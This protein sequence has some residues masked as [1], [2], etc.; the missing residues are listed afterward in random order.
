MNINN[1]AIY[2]NKTVVGLTRG[3][4]Y[5]YKA[6]NLSSFTN[7]EQASSRKYRLKKYLNWLNNTCKQKHMMM[8][9][10]TET[11]F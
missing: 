5:V 1:R 10:M 3:T 9:E 2:Y 8:S 4:Q 6:P 7:C 11:H